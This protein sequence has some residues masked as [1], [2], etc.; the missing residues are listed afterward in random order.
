[1][2]KRINIGACAFLFI[3]LGSMGLYGQK[4]ET[5][6]GV[7]VVHNIA[8]GSWGKTPRITLQLVRTLGELETQDENLAFHMPAD[9]AVDAGGN[10]YILDSGNH[11]IQKFSPAGKYLSTIGRQG[12]GPAEFYFPASLDLDDRGYLYVSDPNNQRIQILTPAGKDDKIIKIIEGSFGEAAYVRSGQLVLGTGETFLQIGM[13]QEKKKELPRLL[14]VLDLEG[15]VVKEIGDPYDFGE[16]L[17]NRMGNQ[18]GFAVDGN[19]NIY[20]AFGYQ[21]RIEKFSPAGELLWRA[22]R[23]LNYNTDPPKSKG[24]MEASG[25]RV[26]IRM[27]NMNQCAGGVAADDQGR[28]WVVTLNRQLKEEEGVQMQVA[29]TM[30][31]SGTRTKSY[32]ARGNTE[33]QKTDAYRLD[34]FADDGTLLGEIPVDHFVDGIFIFGDRL[35]LLDKVRGAKFYE[36]KISG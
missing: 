29:V 34:V 21:N 30:D 5:V 10:I 15:K 20:L 3:V 23:R 32:K 36:Y 26:S 11:R 7:R 17:V 33:L 25:G 24:K 6:N 35:F 12:Q 1:M 8:G 22:D 14:R 16:M 2:I 31:D 19:G 9:I 28:V 27:P 4:V 18:T 13:E